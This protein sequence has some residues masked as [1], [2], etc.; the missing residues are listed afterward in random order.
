MVQ[1]S[2]AALLLPQV[3]SSAVPVRYGGTATF[4]FLMLCSLVSPSIP[5]P[6]EGRPVLAVAMQFLLALVTGNVAGCEP[7]FGVL[8]RTTCI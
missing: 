7:A 6:L 5:W 1:E 4:L 2:P 3:A 8:K